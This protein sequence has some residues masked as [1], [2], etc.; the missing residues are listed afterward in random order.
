M[1]EMVDAQRHSVPTMM[2]FY[3]SAP[4]SAHHEDG[5]NIRTLHQQRIASARQQTG[6]FHYDVIEISS[7]EESPSNESLAWSLYCSAPELQA[8]AEQGLTIIQE[9]YPSGG[10]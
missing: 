7:C 1:K 5:N 3:N 10:S 2:C 6:F 9:K 4:P 8:S